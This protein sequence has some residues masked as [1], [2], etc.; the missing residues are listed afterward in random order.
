MSGVTSSAC[1]RYEADPA[2]AAAQKEGQPHERDDEQQ[3]RAGS[4]HHAQGHGA[5]RR[6]CREPGVGRLGRRALLAAD[7]RQTKQA[8]GNDERHDDVAPEPA[9][10]GACLRHLGERAGRRQSEQDDE[11]HPCPA[12]PV[13]IS[14]AQQCGG[15]VGSACDPS[16]YAG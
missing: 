1:A 4:S 13:C 8:H 10:N 15:Q 6:Q 5:R 2:E 9:Q 3:S 7:R 14:P 11:D 16:R 12:P